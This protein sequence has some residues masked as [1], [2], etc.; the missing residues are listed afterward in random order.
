[1]RMRAILAG[2]AAAGLLALPAMAQDPAP[3]AA[4]GQY[5]TQL[6]RMLAE[7]TQGTCL[8]ALM[9]Q[10]LLDFC[11]GQIAAMA[12]GLQSL[13]AIESTTFVRADESSGARVEIWS[14][15]YASGQTLNWFIGQQQPDGK[16]AAVGTVN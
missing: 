10:P 8:E 13:G 16:F 14:I 5:G 11:N 1:M 9:A 3:A 12:Q 15:K 2:V 6:T 4:D 7:A